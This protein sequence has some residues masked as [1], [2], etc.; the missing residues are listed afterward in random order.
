MA[1]RE[2][3]IIVGS[4]HIGKGVN[5]LFDMYVEPSVGPDARNLIEFGVGTALVL[6]PRFVRMPSVADM[7]LTV[8]GGQMT[9]K[10]WDYVESKT[11]PAAAPV[12]AP[13]TAPAPTPSPAEQAPAPSAYQPAGPMLV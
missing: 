3:G 10:I 12:Y 9:T 2:T 4:Q 1:W 7:A 6:I 11:A 13:A 8:I 5:K